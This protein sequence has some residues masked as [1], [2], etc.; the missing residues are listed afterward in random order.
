MFTKPNI[1]LIFWGGVLVSKCGS[2]CPGNNSL[3]SSGWDQT[4]SSMPGLPLW[5]DRHAPPHPA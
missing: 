2:G 3:C 4:K 1:I 5:D